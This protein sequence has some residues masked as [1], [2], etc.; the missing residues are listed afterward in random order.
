M[1]GLLIF[2]LILIAV[3]SYVLFAPFILEINSFSNFYSVRFLYL[4]SANLV[5]IDNRLK[6]NIKAVGWHLLMDQFAKSRN[7]L[8]K[9][10]KSSKTNT[11]SHLA[12]PMPKNALTEERIAWHL[13]HIKHCHC[14]EIPENLTEEIKKLNIKAQVTT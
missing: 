11:E 10:L 9:L 2:G 3:I 14:R 12:H 1:T 6:I 4:A 7:D 5:L 13:E 8:T